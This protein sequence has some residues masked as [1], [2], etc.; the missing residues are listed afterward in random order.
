MD[1]AASSLAA[2][3]SARH[4]PRRAL[5]VARDTTED[6]SSH[7][8]LHQAFLLRHDATIARSALEVEEPS[9]RAPGNSEPERVAGG[10]LEDLGREQSRANLIIISDEDE[11]ERAVTRCPPR[12]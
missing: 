10:L 1:H 11:R 7:G 3:A 2:L 9:T 8:G 4:V 6:A 12:A 5:V